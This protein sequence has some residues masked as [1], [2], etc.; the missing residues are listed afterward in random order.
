ML[1]NLTPNAKD[2]LP[3]RLEWR[4][5]PKRRDADPVNCIRWF[6]LDVLS[7][8]PRPHFFVAEVTP[9]YG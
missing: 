8:C 3:G 1:V 2:Q 6:D 4:R 7:S 9:L 5:S